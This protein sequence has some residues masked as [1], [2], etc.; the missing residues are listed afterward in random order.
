MAKLNHV[1]FFVSDLDKSVKFYKDIFGFKE[2]DHFMSGKAKITTLDMGGVLLELICPP[3]AVLTPPA[4]SWSHLAIHEPKFDEVVARV[5]KKKLEKRMMTMDI[6]GRLC[7]FND[8]DG[9]TI[10]ISEK[11]L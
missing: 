5:D 3:G 10:E 1:G 9:H 11:G 7:F 4:G 6:G 2:V 8:P